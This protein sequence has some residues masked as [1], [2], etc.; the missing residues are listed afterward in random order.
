MSR[1]LVIS[2]SDLARDP[3]VD[4]QISFLAGQHEVIAAGFAPPAGRET[5]FVNL[6]PPRLQGG[7][8][9]LIRRA[10]WTE[11][12]AESLALRIL[13]RH[14]DAFW[15]HPLNR[16]AAQLLAGVRADVVI[17]NDLSALPLA[18]GVAGDAPVIFDAHELSTEEHS[19]IRWWRLLV[20][21]H[22]DALLRESLPRVAQMTT[23]SGGIAKLYAE[24]YGIEPAVVTNAP[25]ASDLAPSPVG[26]PIRL[27]HHGI[28]VA[29]RRLEL[30]IEAM[31]QLD[32][33]FTLDLMLMPSQPRYLA[34]LRR[35]VATRPRIS[36][37]DPVPQRSIVGLCNAY[38]VGVFVLPPRNGNQFHVLPNKLFEFIQA[39]LAV[40][41]GPSPE[42]AGVVREHDCG[43]VTGDFTP[44]SLAAALGTLTPDNVAD[45]KRHSH[46]AAGQLNA[47]RNRAAVLKLVA[48]ALG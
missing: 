4:R 38:D 25:P 5:E 45:Y 11:G 46:Q 29:E 10:R 15:R 36:L 12:Y 22:A 1:V 18:A 31:D 34:R 9:G 21:P 43:L 47:E 24:R 16:L 40:V 2:F 23:V 27:I 13:G 26:H 14:L 20:A 6:S 7:M 39:R 30:M 28:A 42:M 48:G 17:A 3:R 35:L 33:R 44:E 37:L 19:Q 8:Q 32:D 41:V